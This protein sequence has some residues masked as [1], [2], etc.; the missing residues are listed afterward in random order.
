MWWKDYIL[1]LRALLFRR[2]MDEELQEELQFHIEMQTRKNRRHEPDTA[3]ATRQARLQFGSVVRA[4]EECHEQRGISSIEIL[5]KD[6]C[7]A[8]RR[9]RKNLRFTIIAVLT[10]ALGIGAN[11][12]V[13]SM[14]NALLFH[15]YNFRGLDRIVLVWQDRGTDAGFDQRNIAPGDAADIASHANIFQALATTDCHMLTVGS[16]YEVLPVDGCNVSV[17]FFDLLGVSPMAGRSFLAY[18]EQPGQDA[19]AVVSYAFWQRQFGGDP[20]TVGKTIRI[21]GRTYTVIGI[22]PADINYPIGVQMWIPLALTPA[23]RADRS[24]FSFSAIARLRPGISVAQARTALAAFNAQLTSEYPR[25]N[26]GRR[27]TLLPLGRELY[28]FTLPLFSLLQVAAGFVLLLACAN[29]ANLLFARMIRRQ[30]EV[31]LRAALGAGRRR[32]AQLFLSETILFSVVAGVAAGV[33]SLWTVRLLRTSI[34][35]EWRQWVPGWSGIQVDLSVLAFTILLA[36]AVGV[37][38]GL[39]TLAYS[40]R[41]DLNYTLKEGGPWSMSPARGRVS[42]ALVVVQVIFAL[43]LLVSAGLTIK[44]FIRLANIYEGFQPETVMEIGPV[45]HADFYQTSAKIANFYRQ[46]LRQTA[47]LPGVTAA[48]VVGNPPAS[49]SNNDT[50][51]FEIE[52]RPAARPGEELSAGLQ[53]ISPGYF[54]TLRVPMISGRRFSETDDASSEPVAIV[55]GSMAAKFWPHENAVGHHLRLLDVNSGVDPPVDRRS[56]PASWLTVVGVVDDVRQNWWNSSSDPVMYRPLMQ[57]PERG[58]VLIF[59]VTA[60]PTAYI[61]L[62]RSI[63]RRLDST[64]VLDDTQTLQKNVNDS[65]GIIRIMG[66]LMGTFGAVALALSA[67]G[68]YGVLSENVARRTREIGIRVAL[69]GTP[70]AVRRLVVGQAMKLTA[71]GLI[72]AVP[73]ALLINR[74]MTSFV[75]GIVPMDLAVIV[76]F[77]GVLVVVALAAAYFP[78][79]RAMRVDP[80]VALRYE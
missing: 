24:R 69:G 57:A 45:L 38:F 5:A 60:N 3:Q 52:G 62:V 59:R 41:V 42:S 78:A 80:T 77:T 73:T 74:A 14:V 49:N 11:T 71:V 63:I 65:I 12:A 19:V 18:E 4:T 10:L 9:L 25:T 20:R 66:I 44:G 51:T 22:M 15:P 58:L 35:P 8:G 75:L 67:L 72:I 2:R 32:L 6:L 29:L 68:V 76:E 56:N 43:V 23:K 26:S 64:V 37:V 16:A 27:T 79:R 46:L 53:I 33:V 36:T 48:A 17:N 28:Q 54:R 13:F 21:N 39:A 47:A 31:A 7:F 40:R 50:S 1:R 55:S 30:R 61:S 34:S 70:R